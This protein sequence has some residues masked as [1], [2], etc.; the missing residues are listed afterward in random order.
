[1]EN[2]LNQSLVKERIELTTKV[3]IL[4][5]VVCKFAL[6]AIELFNVAFNYPLT[7]KR[8][9]QHAPNNWMDKPI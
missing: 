4:L 1:M 3:F 9:F 6:V 8:H 7:L 5:T 2:K